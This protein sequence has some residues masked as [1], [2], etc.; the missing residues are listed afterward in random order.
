[1]FA[2]L[3]NDNSRLATTPNDAVVA[4]RI[5]EQLSPPEGVSSAQEVAADLHGEQ[6]VYTKR[7]LIAEVPLLAD[8]SLRFLVPASTP[9]V[10]ELL[11]AAGNVIDRQ[12]EEEQLGPGETQPRMIQPGE[13]NGICGGCHNAM[14]GT[15]TGVAPGPDVLTGASTHSQASQSEALDLYRD[16]SDRTE[17]PVSS[18]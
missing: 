17:V 7:R 10:F 6:Q 1:L 8:G 3:L 2:A 18:P 4:V 16:P 13:F 15:E 5:L 12:R 9:L 11:D 14:D